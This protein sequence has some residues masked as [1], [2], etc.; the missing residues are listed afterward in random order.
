MTSRRD[1][2]ALYI[3][4]S[5]GRTARAIQITCEQCGEETLIR[6]QSKGRF[7]SRACAVTWRHAQGIMPAKPRGEGSPGW[8]AGE[9]TY[10]AMHKRVVRARGRA[11]HCDLREAAGCKSLTFQWAWIHDT[12]PGD[13]QN[14]RQLCRT[15]HSAYDEHIGASNARASL[16]AGQAAEIRA[17]YAAGRP[18]YRVLAQE[19]GVAIPTIAAIVLGR[20]YKETE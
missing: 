18:P 2:N 14:Y 13:P 6:A 4:D 10:S 19:Y 8:K 1:P 3:T 15:C 12:D 9:A 16:T 5:K 20:R 17:R 7:C 11:D